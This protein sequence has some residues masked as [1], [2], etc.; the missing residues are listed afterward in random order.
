[1]IEGGYY[2]GTK[3][4]YIYERRQSSFKVLVSLLK[5]K[6]HFEESF[7]KKPEEFVL[8]HN[9]FFQILRT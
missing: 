5:E 2:L 7:G 4:V 3:A 8:R 9:N 1:M 6:H